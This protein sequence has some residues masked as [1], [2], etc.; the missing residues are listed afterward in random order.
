VRD[1]FGHVVTAVRTAEG[2]LKLITWE[3]S[4][5]GRTVSRLADSGDQ[6]GTI[7]DNSLAALPDGVVSAVRTAEG[8]L[9]LIGWAV[10]SNGAITRRSDSAG[11]AGTST[12]INLVAGDGTRDGAGR[13]VSLVTAVRTAEGRLKL[14][15][16]S[17]TCVRVHFKVLTDPSVSTDTMLSS[18]RQVY[19]TAGMRVQLV[20]TEELDLPTLTDVDAGSCTLGA[21]TEEQREL[22]THRNNV[23]P[24]DMVVYFVRSVTSDD[25]ALNGCASH[26]DG[27]P[28]A[29]VARI[30]TQWTLGH[31][32]GHVLGLRH[33]S[34]TDRLMTG[35]GTAN[36]TNPPPDPDRPGGFHDA[37][38]P[39][40]VGMYRELTWHLASTRSVARS[41]STNPTTASS[42]AA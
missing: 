2:N 28:G 20:S 6:A 18:M 27:R 24:G 21:T 42:P 10:A 9:K 14:I 38:E 13:S 25:G 29:V 39:T 34:D 23:E 7:G 16:W 19:T 4:A 5:D 31:E 15:T 40:D 32:I 33:V 41:T 35:G 8:S 1:R 37:A 22:F 30:A 36:I 3:I 12:L 11:Q 26:P 17:P